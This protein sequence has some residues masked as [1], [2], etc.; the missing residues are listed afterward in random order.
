M[1]SHRMYA[2]RVMGRSGARKGTGERGAGSGEVSRFRR[3]EIFKFGDL[4]IFIFVNLGIYTFG[5]LEI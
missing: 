3:F 5:S 1:I 2:R 4:G